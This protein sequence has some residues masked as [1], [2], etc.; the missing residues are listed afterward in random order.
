MNTPR[1][2]KGTAAAVGHASPPRESTSTR[3][4]VT[5]GHGLARSLPIKSTATVYSNVFVLPELI[6]YRTMEFDRSYGIRK[7]VLVPREIRDTS[8][9]WFDRSL[10]EYAFTL[11]LP[12]KEKLSISDVLSLELL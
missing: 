10:L 12:D 7:K 4:T 9:T 2:L 1:F 5:C 8:F 6:V 11:T 3:T